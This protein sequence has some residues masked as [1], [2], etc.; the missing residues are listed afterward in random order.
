ME[1]NG[2][3]EE[4]QKGNKVEGWAMSSVANGKSRVVNDRSK[5]VMR[6]SHGP[7]RFDRLSVSRKIKLNYN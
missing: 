4:D 7:R 6:Q 5:R 3:E 2:S 1:E